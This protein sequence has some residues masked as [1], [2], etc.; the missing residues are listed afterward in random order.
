MP[1]H[2]L[3]AASDG[4]LAFVAGPRLLLVA[5]PQDATFTDAAWRAVQQDSGFQSVLDLLTGNGL[6]ATPDFALIEWLGGSDARLIVRGATVVEVTDSAGPGSIS[7]AGV[8]T[9]V[10]RTLPGVLGIALSVPNAV[11]AVSPQLPLDAGVALVAR[12]TMGEPALTAVTLV[13]AAAPVAALVAAPDVAVVAP[14]AA[15]DVEFDV[16]ATRAGLPDLDTKATESAAEGGYDYLFG[17]TVHRAVSDAAVREPDSEDP[18]AA[19]DGPTVGDHDGN[20][21]L[22]SDIAKLRGARKHRTAT[23]AVSLPPDAPKL[24]LV[25]STTGA[26]EPIEQQILVG[27]SP[28]VSRVSGG[29]IPRLITISGRDQDISRNHVQVSLEGGTVVVTDLHSKNGTSI[30][31]PGKVAQK[32][33]AGEPASVIVGTVVDLGGGITLTVD[34]DR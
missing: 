11:S 9:W 25:V 10:E 8:S 17:E 6:A 5:L 7:A 14:D 20:T 2:V 1:V 34:E 27:R 29:Q 16:G 13:A 30:V 24:V 18:A 32:L 23:S 19:S 33:R 22:T 26:R 31:L 12:V 4:W 28:S 21:V 3:P 15:P